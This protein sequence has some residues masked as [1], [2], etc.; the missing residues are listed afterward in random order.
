MA[1]VKLCKLTKLLKE[2]RYSQSELAKAI[3][4]SNSVMFTRMQTKTA[5][6]LTEA[7]AIADLLSIPYGS[8]KEYLL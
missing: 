3:G 2:N 8:I 1:E 4:M 6:T 7:L 5:W